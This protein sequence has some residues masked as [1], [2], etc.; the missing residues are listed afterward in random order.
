MILLPVIGRELRGA[1]RHPFT[2]NLRVLG[3]AA[4]LVAFGCFGLQGNLGPGVGGELFR[5]LHTALFLAI[6]CLVP[7]LTA[8]VLSRERREG[9]LPLLFLTPLRPGD[10][11]FAKG[12]A[13]GVRAFT[14]WLAVVPVL[15][16]S[17]LGG[18]L[19]W[20]ELMISALINF[21]SICMGLASG[22]LASAW[23]RV[24][25]RALALSLCFAAGSLAVFLVGFPWVA[26][27][28][29][30]LLAGQAVD[31]FGLP[32][33]QVGFKCAVNQDD[34]WR[35][36]L[37]APSAGWIRSPVMVAFNGLSGVGVVALCSLSCSLLLVR[38]AAWRISRTW[39]EEPLSARR[40]RFQERLCQPVFFQHALRRWLNWQLQRN[41]IG[42]LEQ[43]SWS[44]RLVVWSWLAVV[45]CIYSSLF[46]NLYLYQRG[47][48][49]LQVALATLLAGSIALSASGSF[50]RERE[51]GV[52]ELLLVA[53]LREWQ[54]IGGRVVGLWTQF[55]PSAMLLCAVWVFGASI[56][57]QRPELPSVL[58]Y[59]VTFATIPV[60][61]LY[62]SLATANFI[63]A[64]VGTLLL[65]I[66]IPQALVQAW[67]LFDDSASIGYHSEEGT[68]F[69]LVF[70][71]LFQILSAVCLAWRLQNNLRRRRFALAARGG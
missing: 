66:V 2:Y 63:V 45:A 52:L 61:G 68:G 36:F 42:W 4:L 62:F 15:T 58:L 14:L 3:V 67:Y 31:S 27:A 54:I 5:Y 20:L 41:P 6:W 57:S 12:L 33:L 71:V 35:T 8:A 39:R 44:G 19:S 40:L 60:V 43:R 21:S 48:H 17:F 59:A 55:L 7:L 9:T 16:I 24:W 28:V 22:L 32:S 56:L 47:F 34:F 29:P 26:C 50:R 37:N 65:Q 46:A 30:Q 69:A 10:M 70:P 11:V 23:A 1:A 18:G 51:T 64:L 38:L 53:P 25:S 49:G 13:H